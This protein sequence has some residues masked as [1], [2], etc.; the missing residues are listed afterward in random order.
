[1]PKMKNPPPVL[2]F[3]ERAFRSNCPTKNGTACELLYGH[4]LRTRWVFPD[5][6]S[7][8]SLFPLNPMPTINSI[9]KDTV[10]NHHLEVP[11]VGFAWQAADGFCFR[12]PLQLKARLTFEDFKFRQTPFAI[13]TR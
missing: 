7:E 8:P 12:L 11:E 2:S 6:D 3:H 4:T 13:R 10:I 9:S 1:M 5:D